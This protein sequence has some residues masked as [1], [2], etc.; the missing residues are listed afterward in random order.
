MK[1]TV[2]ILLIVLALLIFSFLLLNEYIYNEK[3]IDEISFDGPL[4]TFVNED[5]GIT[6]TYPEIIGTQYISTIDWP[7]QVRV[8]EEEI[9]CVE[10][11]GEFDRA[12]ITER[13][14]VDGNEYCVTTVSEGAA[15]SVYRQ[16]AYGY[17]FNDQTLMFIFS[18]QFPQCENYDEEQMREC[19]NEQNNFDLDRLMDMVI[20]S[21]EFMESQE[22]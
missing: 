7:P 6:F 11:G 4:Q 12:G 8:L 16:Y 2:I 20:Q 3:Q 14:E 1:K 5:S 17:E 15:G 19:E 22:I 10:A 9:S 18:M 13:T 21:V